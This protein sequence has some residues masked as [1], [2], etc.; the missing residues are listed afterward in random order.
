[1]TSGAV[2]VEHV[3]ARDGAELVHPAGEPVRVLAVRGADCHRP[4]RC[5]HLEPGPG[6]G[7]V[8]LQPDEPYGVL[9][10]LPQPPSQLDLGRL[11]PKKEKLN[12]VTMLTPWYVERRA[13]ER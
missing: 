7:A 9:P 11:A 6:V 10:G 12:E 2:D 4:G 3:V 5:A 1:M 13:V 8:A